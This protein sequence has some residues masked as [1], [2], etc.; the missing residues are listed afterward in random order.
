MAVAFFGVSGLL[1][2]YL[3][4]RSTFLPR[5]LGILMMISS[6]GWLRYFYPPLRY[7][8]FMFVA[9]LSLF[10]AA[11]EIFWLIVYGVDEE[12]WR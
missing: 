12:R 3:V 2:G 9:V 10:V 8:P 1:N 5:A 11:V 6:V 4:Y 7:P